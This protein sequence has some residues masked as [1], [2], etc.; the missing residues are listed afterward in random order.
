MSLHSENLI[1]LPN[2]FPPECLKFLEKMRPLEGKRVKITFKLGSGSPCVVR[3]L[4]ARVVKEKGSY[5]SQLA[6]TKIW[7]IGKKAIYPIDSDRVQSV[8]EDYPDPKPN[9]G[10]GTRFMKSIFT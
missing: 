4:H 9:N 10:K 5:K 3:L 2:P 1:R 7:D 8:Q 6:V